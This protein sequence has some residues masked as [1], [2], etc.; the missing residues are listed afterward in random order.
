MRQLDT[1]L[2]TRRT[3]LFRRRG[4]RSI[5]GQG[6]QKRQIHASTKLNSRSPGPYNT[7]VD[8]G[9][10]PNRLFYA[11]SGRLYA[12][13]YSGT[14]KERPT[15]FKVNC[16]RGEACLA[17]QRPDK[18]RGSEE[19]I[20]VS[21]IC[22]PVSLPRPDHREIV[23]LKGKATRSDE[24]MQAR[25]RILSRQTP[26]T[27]WWTCDPNRTDHSMSVGVGFLPPLFGHSR[28]HPYNLQAQPRPSPS[29]TAKV[30]E[31]PGTN[32]RLCRKSIY[33]NM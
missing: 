32:C 5:K 4:D 7:W 24:S 19:I 33:A 31:P 6:D 12:H 30:G 14:H 18:G 15:T 17:H 11:C 16:S 28:G 22:A 21:R 9:F 3:C 8:A 26:T 29:C 25:N 2:Y 20:L 1:Y 23:L 13:V 27:H 10:Q